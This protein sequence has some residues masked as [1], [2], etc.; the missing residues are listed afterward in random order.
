MKETVFKLAQER[1][2]R[3]PAQTITDTDYADDIATQANS[4][5]HAEFQLH[6]LENGLHV[7]A[8]NTGYLYF[9]QRSNIS[10]LKGGSLK[11]LDKFTYLRSSV[12]STEKNI[13]TRLAMAWATI[14]RQPVLWKSDLS[15]KIKRSFIHATL[16]S[17]L[18]YGCTIWTLTK[19]M[20]KKLTAITQECPELYWTGPG[21]NTL[22]SSSSTATYHP[23][24]KLS[25]LDESDMQDTAEEVGT[26]L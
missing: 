12:S 13:N 1:S 24:S 20:E 22:Q 3:Y 4:P 26:N 11:L 25:K 16:V 9:N 6:S 23:S 17:D 8:I 15:D 7:N 14:H 18:L 10:T 19:R 21:D 5:T 2:R